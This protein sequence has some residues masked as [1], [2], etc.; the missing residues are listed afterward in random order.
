VPDPVIVRDEVGLVHGPVAAAALDTAA[1]QLGGTLAASSLRS[2]DHRPGSGATAV[3]DV[4][5]EAPDGTRTAFVLALTTD[6]AA[7]EGATGTLVLASGDTRLGVWVLPHDPTLTG[8]VPAMDS[9]AVASLLTSCGVPTQPADVR[10]DI[11]AYRP[12]RR[13]VVEA[14]APGAGL[15][16]KVVPP[17]EAGA[18]HRHHRRLVAAG[19]P[20]PRSLG[21]DARGVVVLARLPGRT[22][23]QEMRAGRASPSAA[24]L[25]EAIDRLP[26]SLLEAP[27]R[28]SWSEQSYHHVAVLSAA[29]P[30]MADVVRAIAAEA[31]VADD[32][33]ALP[34]VPVHGDLY[35]AQVMVADGRV[36]GILDLDTA[37]PGRRI[38]DEA[39]LL[40][41]LALLPLAHPDVT[42]AC[43]VA[44]HDHLRA[45]TSEP[46]MLWRRTALVLLTLATGPARNRRAGWGERTDEWIRLPQVAL[47]M[48]DER[49]W[50]Q[51]PELLG[52]LL[53][54]V[55]A[56]S[57]GPIGA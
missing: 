6:A 8:L 46:S 50:E 5:V 49:P 41:H 42:D 16:L 19:V 45:A 32:V 56:R 24:D 52:R 23:R 27:R 3:H 15:F 34:L 53:G 30:P 25:W 54:A 18:L 55:R 12:R 38:D 40:A 4:T 44:L 22:W 21:V 33:A 20:A 14:R 26:D 10:L 31:D 17:G 37:G 1:Q 57:A 9:V 11:R 43:A 28:A 51:G 2:V 36:C 47:E 39:C 7:V 35:E 13:A 29:R 48:L